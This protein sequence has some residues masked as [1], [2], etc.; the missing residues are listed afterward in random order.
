[1]YKKT[2]IKI[3]SG[4][5]LS[6][7]LL[8]AGCKKE[9]KSSDEYHITHANTYNMYTTCEYSAEEK[10]NV[11]AF[12]KTYYKVIAGKAY[13]NLRSMD[14]DVFNMSPEDIKNTAY[15]VIIADEVGFSYD[16]DKVDLYMTSA[17]TAMKSENDMYKCAEYLKYYTM[18]RFYRHN[19]AFT[20]EDVEFAQSK[21]DDLIESLGS[22]SDKMKELET[23]DIMAQVFSFYRAGFPGTNLHIMITK[24]QKNKIK[25]FIS[26]F[27]KYE[28]YVND[29][30][31][32]AKI[33]EIDDLFNL[34]FISDT[35]NAVAIHAYEKLDDSVSCVDV[36]KWLGLSDTYHKANF[37]EEIHDK[38]KE[39]LNSIRIK[40]GIY[41]KKSENNTYYD[42]ESI[43][44]GNCLE[45]RV[46][47]WENAVKVEE[48]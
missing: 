31:S 22:S 33:Y 3:M 29:I 4:L 23:L 28:H 37:D 38:I 19:Y 47:Q 45:D 12:L 39:Y 7:V 21:L 11:Q 25:D 35:E 13:F 46:E 20:E 6:L 41:G 5:A 40:K 18:Y 15:G 32:F 42:F 9:N 48:E 44:C 43:A 26:V 36:Y 10:A 34:E 24:E 16:K 17:E 2:I 30:S 1:M 8:S 14:S 27:C